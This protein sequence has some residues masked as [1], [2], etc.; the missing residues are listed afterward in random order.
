[1]PY[2][3]LLRRDL[4]QNWNYNDP[5]LMSGEPGYEMD[6]RKFKMGDGQT[7]WSQ[8]PYSSGVTGAKGSTGDAGHSAELIGTFPSRTAL[9]NAYPTPPHPY[10]WAFAIGDQPEDLWVYR[11]DPTG[12]WN[13]EMIT[14]PA[15]PTG[16]TGPIGVTGPIGITGV[17]GATGP[18]GVTGATGPIGVTGPT[19]SFSYKVYTALLGRTG[20]TAPNPIVLQNTLGAVT[21]NYLS[22]GNYRAASSNLFTT[23]KTTVFIQQQTSGPF[24]NTLNAVRVD[25]SNIYIAQNSSSGPNDQDWYF[26]VSFEIRVYP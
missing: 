22:L 25:Q 16:A 10:Y 19:G 7:P 9:T 20:A 13:Y 12:I 23:N 8:L 18:I 3:I 15:G 4:S 26:P 5:V 1:M 2:R 21:F 14:L 6:T 17:T 11:A 24:G